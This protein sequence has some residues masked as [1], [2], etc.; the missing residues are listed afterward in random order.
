MKFIVIT[1]TSSQTFEVNWVEVHTTTGSFVVQ[2][3]HAPLIAPL[4]PNKEISVSLKD[5]SSTIM[6]LAGGILE[7]KRDEIILL[8]YS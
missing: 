1:P 8:T 6:N 5:G 3:G 4:T 7:V 2:P